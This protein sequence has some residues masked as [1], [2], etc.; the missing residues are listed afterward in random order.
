MYVC[1]YVYIYIYI[2]ARSRG[3]RESSDVTWWHAVGTQFE[4]P[5]VV[6]TSRWTRPVDKVKQHLHRVHD[7]ISGAGSHAPP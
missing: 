1:M 3:Q 4:V 6:R 2:C 7:P 5:S